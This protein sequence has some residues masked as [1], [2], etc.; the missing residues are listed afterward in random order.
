MDVED[1]LERELA[2]DRHRWALLDEMAAAPPFGVQAV[3]AYALK[4]R[5]VE[6]WAALSDEAEGLRV[7]AGISEAVLAGSLP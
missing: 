6:K 4:L 3:F 7:A 2:L 5:I 1:P